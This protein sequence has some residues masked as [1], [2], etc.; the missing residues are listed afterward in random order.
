MTQQKL[1]AQ[2]NGRQALFVRFPRERLRGDPNSILVEAAIRSVIPNGG[3][4]VLS[5]RRLGAIAGVDRECVANFLRKRNGVQSNGRRGF[6]VTV[7]LPSRGWVKFPVAVLKAKAPSTLR[8][9]LVA[10]WDRPHTAQQLAER[11]GKTPRHIRRVLA[12]LHRAGI[13][14]KEGSFWTL[15]PEAQRAWEQSPNRLARAVAALC[16]PSG[17]SMSAQAAGESGRKCGSERDGI[18]DPSRPS[19]EEKREREAKDAAGAASPVSLAQLEAERDSLSQQLAQAKEPA[20]EPVRR[21]L[22][23]YCRVQGS[24]ALAVALWREWERVRPNAA[25]AERIEELLRARLPSMARE[26]G[27]KEG[28]ARY[29]VAQSLMHAL[30]AEG[31]EDARVRIEGL[32]V[33]RDRVVWQLEAQAEAAQVRFFGAAGWY[34]EAEGRRVLAISE[35]VA[36]EASVAWAP[37]GREPVDVECRAAFWEARRELILARLPTGEA[38]PPT[39]VPEESRPT[40][41][42]GEEAVPEDRLEGLVRGLFQL[43]DLI[44]NPPNLPAGGWS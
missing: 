28:R 3:T 26:V 27:R 6:S 32:Q 16:P 15:T 2:V 10:L 23:A 5:A 30:V 22:L 25:E 29:A 34:E 17:G 42:W 11:F 41:A 24:H 21:R 40:A 19:L 35:R 38:S 8:V 37:P 18:F 14:C 33:R 20:G 13:A 36:V 31:C 1:T 7:E 12:L 4:S 9:V 39:P 43:R 44:L